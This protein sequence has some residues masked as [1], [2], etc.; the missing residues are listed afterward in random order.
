MPIM[1]F[2]EPYVMPQENGNRTDVRWMYL[3]DST[4]GNGLLVVAD[5]LLSMS[6]WP[7]TEAGVNAAKHTD[8]L[9]G[10]GFITLN[11]D[12]RQMGVGGNT[13]W[14]KYAAPVEKYQI[15]PKHYH[16]GFFLYPCKQAKNQ[17]V[18]SE[19]AKNLRFNIPAP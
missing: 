7:Y 11:I 13:S 6:A 19:A 12:L 2:M 15:P 9:K 3:S 4:T 17:A 5:S 1:Q 10:A 14:N 16:Y 18:L 8:E